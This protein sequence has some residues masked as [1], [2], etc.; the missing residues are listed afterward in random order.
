MHTQH[1]KPASFHRLAAGGDA[2][3]ARE[4]PL[5]RLPHGAPAS[6]EPDFL[7]VVDAE[8]GRDR[9]RDCRCRTSATSCTTSAGTAAA[10]PATAPDRRYL[11]VP[12][13]RSSASTSSIA[14]DPRRPQMDKVIEPEEIVRETKLTAPHT[15]H[16][17]PDG[18]IMISM[19]G[20]ATA[21]APAA[22]LLDAQI[23][24]R[25]PLGERRRRGCSS[26]TTSGTSRGTT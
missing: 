4:A 18:N 15:V 1:D 23:R 5:R 11:I 10:P 22:S 25:R 2:G 13:F 19:L 8:E 7:A 17:L 16:C 20:D 3:A 6:S 12:G 24:G 26:T 9:P 14:D 21:T